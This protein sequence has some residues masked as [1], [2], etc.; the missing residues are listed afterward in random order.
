MLARACSF[1]SIIPQ[2]IVEL[3]PVVINL[4]S[5]LLNRRCLSDWLDSSIIGVDVLPTLLLQITFNLKHLVETQIV[6]L[7]DAVSMLALG[8]I[9]SI[10]GD[11]RE[12]TLPKRFIHLLVSHRNICWTLSFKL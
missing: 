4:V 8:Y 5:V 11:R 10:M 12:F 6:L 9:Y 7:S 2:N 1:D 3:F